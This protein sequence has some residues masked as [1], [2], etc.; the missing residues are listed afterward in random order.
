M[1]LIIINNSIHE[2]K[3]E[4]VGGVWN[5]FWGGGRSFGLKKSTEFRSWLTHK[6][7]ALVSRKKWSIYKLQVKYENATE[8]GL[9]CRALLCSLCCCLLCINIGYN[10]IDFSFLELAQSMLFCHHGN[11]YVLPS[12]LN[13]L[14][15]KLNKREK[16][17][18]IKS[19][20]VY[21]NEGKNEM[22]C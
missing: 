13:N 6:L 4:G 1:C 20:F 8:L 16:K 21:I 11:F 5:F 10:G 3:M 9:P 2:E 18:P 12:T 15:D 19:L 22:Y 14:I 17:I 7:D